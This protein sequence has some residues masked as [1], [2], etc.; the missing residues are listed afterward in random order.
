MGST[1]SGVPP[2]YQL[3]EARTAAQFDAG[4]GLIEE[5][6]AHIGASMGVDL[7]SKISRPSFVNCPTC[8]ERRPAA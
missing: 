7:V 1:A 6:A 3:V 5:Y 8:T 4:R 2:A